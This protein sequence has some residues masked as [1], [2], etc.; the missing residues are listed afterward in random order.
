MKKIEVL[1]KLMNLEHWPE[2]SNS[3]PVFQGWKW[4]CTNKH[5]VVLVMDAF[6]EQI[7]CY[8]MPDDEFIIDESEWYADKFKRASNKSD[9]VDDI[10]EHKHVSQK[11]Y[12]AGPVS[13]IE[14]GNRDKFNS[15]SNLIKA[16]GNIPLSTVVL[17]S[18]LEEYEYMILA[19]AMLQMADQVYMLPNWEGSKGAVAEHALAEKLGLVIHYLKA[20]PTNDN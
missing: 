19:M 3:K 6:V 13:S 12:I 16:Q 15:Y 10:F 1:A 17:P 14:G 20:D 8:K 18:G 11:I 4:V 2:V 9:V 5:G 7:L